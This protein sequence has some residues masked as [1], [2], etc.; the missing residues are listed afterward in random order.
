MGKLL[1]DLNTLEELTDDLNVP[2]SSVGSS[3]HKTSV[4]ILKII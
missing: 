1:Q 2:I 3:M 4:L